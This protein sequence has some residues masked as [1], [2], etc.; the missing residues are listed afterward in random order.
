MAPARTEA[1][2]ALKPGPRTRA[3]ARAPSGG[4]DARGLV[5]QPGLRSFRGRQAEPGAS[6]STLP[7][8]AS[9]RDLG[10]GT[11]EGRRGWEGR[12]ERSPG[13]L[14]HLGTARAGLH[15]ASQGPAHSPVPKSLGACSFLPRFSS[16]AKYLSSLCDE[17]LEWDLWQKNPPSNPG[18]G[19]LSS[20]SNLK[21]YPHSPNTLFCRLQLI[22]LQ[23]IL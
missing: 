9:L 17:T 18:E 10:E 2:L 6:G 19:I 5:R 11:G 13:R 23:V 22:F 15:L 12:G 7:P 21:L 3:R 14:L 8:R 1:L 4:P 20:N 16:G